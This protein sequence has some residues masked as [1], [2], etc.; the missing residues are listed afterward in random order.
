MTT[1]TNVLDKV[2][3][4][5]RLAM[6]G[7]IVG[8]LGVTALVVYGCVSARSKVDTPIVCNNFRPI[9]WVDSDSELTKEQ[10]I[11]H[12]GVWD[13]YCNKD[14]RGGGDD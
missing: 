9:T 12:N 1:D 13:R 6:T 4:N 10:V 7:T 11:E 2:A 14:K 8:A 5:S 3:P